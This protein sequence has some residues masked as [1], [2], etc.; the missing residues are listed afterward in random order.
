MTSRVAAPP[1]TD[2]DQANSPLVLGAAAVTVVLW[3]SSF[4][5][6]RSAGEFYAPGSMA[7]LRM[8]VGSLALGLVAAAVGVR[9]PPRRALLLIVAWGLGWFCFYNLALNQAERTI[10]AGTA[11]ML[12][13]LAPLIVV[14]LGG[15]VLGEGFPRGLLVG[16]PLAFL[17]VVLI[18]SG[19]WT[20]R[21]AIS[22]VLLAV[23]A[24]VLYAG[25]ALVQKRLLRT[26]DATTL[27]W[28]GASAGTVALL[29][30]G[31]AL[32]RDVQAAPASATLGVLYLG[33]FPTAVAFTTWA[34]VLSRTSAGKTAATTYVVPAVTIL[35]SWVLLSEAPT[36]IMLT[37]GLLCLVGVYITRLRR[38]PRPADMASGPGTAA[39][40]SGA[41]RQPAG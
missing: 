30:W 4:V 29:P 28:L 15:L 23:V 2:T 22:G 18:A 6:I 20:G 21:A 36:A 32:L 3:A 40:A 39:G 17:G 24:A 35:L 25:A 31:G 5:V 41:A 26:V 34:Y 16:A 27:T 10:D 7:L 12:V 38:R 14:A 37:G 33:V 19:S 1:P 11:A 13:N 8:V 9:W